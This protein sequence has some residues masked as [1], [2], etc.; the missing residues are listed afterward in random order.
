MIFHLI[1]YTEH[2]YEELFDLV[3]DPHETKN[4]AKDPLYQQQLQ[5]LRNRYK[6]LK[7]AAE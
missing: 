5:K 1:V 3:K 6:Q 7:L 2:G 4:L